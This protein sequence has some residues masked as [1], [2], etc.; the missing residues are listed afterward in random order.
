MEMAAELREKG[1]RVVD[2]SA[3]FRLRDRETYE[4]WYNQKHTRPELLADAVYGLP[5]LY[6][7][8]IAQ[9]DLVANPAVIPR[10]LF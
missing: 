2:L 5:E 10:R 8:K 7:E 6:A 4:A 9:A 3:D 1:V